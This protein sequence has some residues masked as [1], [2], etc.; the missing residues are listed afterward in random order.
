MLK[1]KNLPHIISI[2]ALALLFSSAPLHAQTTGS[3][4]S[5]TSGIG[6]A[7]KSSSDKVSKDDQQMMLDIAHANLAEIETGKL[8]LDK[9]KNDQVKQFAQKMIE[10]H[11]TAMKELE[12]LALSKGIS[13]PAETDLKHKAV[14]TALKALSGDTF[15][16]QYMSRVGVAD[17]E[18][19]HE[20]L[21]K[22]QKNAKDPELKAYAQKILPIVHQ[23]LTMAQK[24]ADKK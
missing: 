23:H 10:D 1:R 19:T 5:T 17:H 16:K 2:A 12:K 8:A 9:S 22:T 20:L 15:D 4:S 24:M 7:G 18:R 11:T 14:A 6:N 13:L 3:D 21:E